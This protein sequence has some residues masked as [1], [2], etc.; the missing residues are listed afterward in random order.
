MAVTDPSSWFARAVARL[1]QEPEPTL[2]ELAADVGVTP[3]HLQRTFRARTGMSPRQL[4]AARR[5]QAA[6]DEL[7]AGTP[8]AIAGYAAGYGSSRQFYEQAGALGMSPA[9][10]R[11]GGRGLVVRWAVID[12]TLGLVLVAATERGVCLVAFSD[13]P[14]DA[15]TDRVVEDLIGQLADRLPAA[16]RVEDPDGLAG[17]AGA[18]AAV[19]DGRDPAFDV[20]L[21]VLGTAFQLRVWGELRRIPAGQTRTYGEVAAALGSP[22]AARA[23]GRACGANPVAVLVPCHRVVGRDGSGTGYRWG[24]DRKQALL[25]REGAAARPL[26]GRR[27]P[28]PPP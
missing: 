11:R 22:G 1:E 27:P 21:D 4:V 19:V 25:Q 26:S 2:A 23:V 9:Q 14:P 17:L 15:P 8:V 13:E 12:T 16:D 6:S 5:L 18:V 3:S 20:P 28:P 7:A 10:Y 24:L